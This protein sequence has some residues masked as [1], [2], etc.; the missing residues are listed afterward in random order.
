MERKLMLTKTSLL[1]AHFHGTLT[2]IEN[3]ITVPAE[4]HFL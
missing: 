1:T 4:F 3:S 2:K